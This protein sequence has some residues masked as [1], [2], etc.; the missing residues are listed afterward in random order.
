MNIE[1]S[2]HDNS[3][4]SLAIQDIDSQPPFYVYLTAR[5]KFSRKIWTTPVMSEEGSLKTYQSIVEALNDAKKK[6]R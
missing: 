4:I 3:E 2:V 1:V 6:I 5:D